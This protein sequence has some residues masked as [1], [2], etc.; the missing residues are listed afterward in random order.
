METLAQLR[1]ENAATEDNPAPTPQVEPVK[2]KEPA[3]VEQ[4]S[5]LEVAEPEEEEE[6]QQA[7]AE[8]WMK[9]DEPESQ[10][11]DRKFTD[12]DVAAA[13]TKL[14]AKLEAKHNTELEEMR[15]K[16]EALQ[17]QQQA[18]QVGA[19]PTREQFYDH[20]DPDEAYSIALGRW[21]F[22][23]EAAQ[24]Q[25]QRAKFEQ[26]RAALEQ[27]QAVRAS[28]DQHFERAAKL[29][30][31]SGIAPELYQSADGRVRSALDEIFPGEGDQVTDFLI[32]L[33]G[34]GSER[35]MYNLGVR[36]DRLEELAKRLKDN[37]KGLSAA[38]YL[39]EL[40][41]ELN[42]PAKRKSNAPAPATQIQGD[43]NTSASNSA[44]KRDYDKA[45]KAGDQAKAFKLKRAAKLGGADTSSW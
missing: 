41:K 29:I 36:K 27:A 3:A 18:P 19:K 23:A 4:E 44:S 17:K 12:G 11:A 15:Q 14:R 30:E 10:T 13:K 5:E 7:E 43:A 40:K 16:L 25:A 33:T 21:T 24:Q 34:E 32:S 37:S 8:D 9:S 31:Q 28:V 22:S 6:G 42:A 39:G 38:V 35:V 2:P 45:I 20:D 26:D 1:A